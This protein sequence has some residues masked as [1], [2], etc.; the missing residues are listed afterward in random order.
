LFRYLA[1][2]AAFVAVAYF[3]KPLVATYFHP[4]WT[5]E[6]V[7][8][9]LERDPN[10]RDVLL[11][12]RENYPADSRA[13][14]EQAAAD[15]NAN[16]MAS[17]NRNAF[18]FMKRFMRGKANAI[19]SAPSDQLHGIAQEYSAMFHVLRSG[20]PALCGRLVMEGFRPGDHPPANASEHLAR[21]A[22]LQ[23]RAAHAGEMGGHVP[24]GALPDR[25]GAAF[26]AAVRAN[27]PTVSP[28]L[29]DQAALRAASP[30][31]QCAAGTA[32]FDAAAELPEESSANVVAQ[33]V[34]DSLSQ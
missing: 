31:R 19:I 34:R 2:V 7:E 4:R 20:D 25:D 18:L 30:D 3:V 23:I 10:M 33:I 6:R 14:L 8:A 5:T 16:D 17:A 22:A 11:A 1:G 28:L 9:E 27:D 15:A 13:L 29:A 26:G 24:R 32:I 21:L 12:L